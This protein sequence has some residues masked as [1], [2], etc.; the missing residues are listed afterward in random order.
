MTSLYHIDMAGL[1]ALL[2]VL[3]LGSRGRREDLHTA[4]TVTI[5]NVLPLTDET[6]IAGVDRL[7][8]SFPTESVS[9]LNAQTT[10]LQQQRNNGTNQARRAKRQATP[11][12]TERK[13]GGV[14]V[15]TGD[16]RGT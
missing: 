5:N 13:V 3:E 9:G 10:C 2:G 12:R 14:F 15:C 6:W 1:V 11:W 8:Y 7:A 16:L 4:V